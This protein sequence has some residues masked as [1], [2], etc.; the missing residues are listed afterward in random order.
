[1]LNF[2]NETQNVKTRNI[3]MQQ[4]LQQSFHTSTRPGIGVPHP[5]ATGTANFDAVSTR[6]AHA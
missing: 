3:E 4:Q 1:V 5:H 6:V 2:D